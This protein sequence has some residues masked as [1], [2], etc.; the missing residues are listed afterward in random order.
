MITIRK[1]KESDVPAV[2]EFYDRIVRWLDA[3]INYPKWMY[4]LYPSE[5]SARAMTKEGAQ[6]LCAEDGRIIG[7]FVLNTDPEGAYH[8]G[9]WSRELPDGSFMVIHALAVAPEYQGKG[10]GS[11]IVRFCIETAKA[12]GYRAIRLDIVPGNLPAQKLYE[13]NGFSYIEDADL[14]RGYAHIPI[15]SLYELNFD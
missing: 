10:L 7:A 8:K 11:E 5:H 14:E 2:G 1:C 4:K 9:H 13:K 15:F 3:H 6:Y 12:G